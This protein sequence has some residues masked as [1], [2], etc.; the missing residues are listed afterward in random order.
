MFANGHGTGASN[1]RSVRNATTPR[2]RD[3]V[4]AAGELIERVTH[5]GKQGGKRLG[6]AR[7]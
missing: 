6:R 2:Q 1:V 4:V 3:L 7:R 5:D